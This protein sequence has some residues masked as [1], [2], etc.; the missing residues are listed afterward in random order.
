V[1]IDRKVSDLNG[2]I[3]QAK[4]NLK[5]QDILAPVSGTIFELKAGTPGF[6]ATSSEPVL[7]IV[8]N[9]NLNAKVF[10]SNKDIGFVKTGM[11][12][13]VRIDSF[14]FSEFG[15]VKG[16][17]ISIGSDAL[18]ADQTHQ[19]ERFPATI[20][21]DKQN[22]IIKGKAITLQSG[23]SLS[24]NVKT[25]DRTV[26]SIFTDLVMKQGDSLKTIR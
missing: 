22:I 19:Y 6:V 25:R 12:V 21:L 8:P 26:M 24:A 11:T 10:I 1:D 14:P 23:M 7:K 15:D 2:Q 4:M 13:D 20:Q 5:Y 18:P 16:K 9:N 17:L 3:S